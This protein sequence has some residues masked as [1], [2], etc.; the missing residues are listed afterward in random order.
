MANRT[1]PP[2]CHD[3]EYLEPVGALED[4][5]YLCRHHSGEHRNALARA[6]PARDGVPLNGRS[7]YVR[8]GTR[9]VPAGIG[10]GPVKVTSEAY[11]SGWDRVFDPKK[12]N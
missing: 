9:Y 7:L 5:S 8:D 3:G 4:G 2:D 12:A 10:K 6:I 1:G 11:R